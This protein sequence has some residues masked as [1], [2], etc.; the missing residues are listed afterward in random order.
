MCTS[1]RRPWPADRTA[2]PAGSLCRW[3]SASRETRLRASPPS[4]FSCTMKMTAF[5]RFG[6]DRSP[7]RRTRTDLGSENRDRDSPQET[8]AERKFLARKSRFLGWRAKEESSSTA[9]WARIAGIGSWFRWVEKTVWKRNSVSQI[10]KCTGQSFTS[11]CLV[12]DS[13]VIDVDL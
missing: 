7:R 6:P 11:F 3:G 2:T 13:S 4:G 12:S 1:C 9:R 5:R 8:K 10:E